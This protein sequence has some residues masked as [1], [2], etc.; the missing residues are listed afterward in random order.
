MKGEYMTQP[1]YCYGDEVIVRGSSEIS[2]FQ[3]YYN[4]FT[5]GSAKNKH[6]F[7]IPNGERNAI[8]VLT[9]NIQ[10]Y[11]PSLNH[12]LN[13]YKLSPIRKNWRFAG[14]VEAI[15]A[16]KNATKARNISPRGFVIKTWPEEGWANNSNEIKA[17]K[18]GVPFENT[19][20]NEVLS[21]FYREEL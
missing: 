13:L 11:T 19:N 5:L 17:H 14:F 7:I 6:C 21:A 20:E 12:A 16:A 15:V 4:N 9:A 2:I 1:T 3:A 8:L 18:I 10:P